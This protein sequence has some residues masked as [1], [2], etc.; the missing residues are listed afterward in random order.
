MRRVF[1]LLLLA[2]S[3]VGSIAGLASAGQVPIPRPPIPRP[4]IPP[5]REPPPPPPPPVPAP[6][7]VPFNDGGYWMLVQP[8]IYQ[9]LGMTPDAAILV[10]D[11]F[12]TDLASIP[13]IARMRFKD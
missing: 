13:A 5:S 10:P 4:S 11:G 3:M 9:P 7:M 1:S 8:V 2:L 12:V 6:V